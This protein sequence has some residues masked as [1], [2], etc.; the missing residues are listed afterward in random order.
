MI[1]VLS[2]ARTFLVSSGR[3]PQQSFMALFR[4]SPHGRALALLALIAFGGCSGG[5]LA[6]PQ[7][8]VSAHLSIVSGNQQTGTVGEPLPKPLIVE[9]RDEAGNAVV[10]RRVAFV[11]TG[12]PATAEWAPDTAVTDGDG[13]AV[14]EWVLGT[15][16][17]IYYAEAR[18]VPS[19]E[20]AEP[21]PLTAE[22][23]AAARPAPPDTLRAESRVTQNARG[24]E[25]VSDP[26]TV[27]VV[28][29]Y[30][31]P[32]AGI[33]VHWEVTAGDGTVSAPVVVTG[34]DGRATVTWTLEN[35]IGLQKLSAT[36][37][38]DVNGSPLVFTAVV[39]F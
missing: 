17:G 15:T 23:T 2:G 12:G 7:P 35:R 22:L 26:P 33:A 37:D 36:V 21:D 19:G 24:G 38:G 39:L 1:Q 14:G 29:R 27:Q 28:D 13:Q 32:L 6:L 10:G 5:D 25:T 3:I 18:L 16:P 11:L 31:N 20:V 4:P 30:G 34:G 9:L 8:S